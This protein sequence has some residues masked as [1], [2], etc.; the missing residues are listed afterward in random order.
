MSETDRG[1]DN[2]YKVYKHHNFTS[3]IA[4]FPPIVSGFKYLRTVLVNPKVG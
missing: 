4:L 2:L 1:F 3:S